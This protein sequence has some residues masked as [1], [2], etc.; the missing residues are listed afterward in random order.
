MKTKKA[1][2]IAVAALVAVAAAAALFMIFTSGGEATPDSPRPAKAKRAIAEPTRTNAQAR[3]KARRGKSNGTTDTS[4]VKRKRRR[5]RVEDPYTPAERRLADNLQDASDENDI[6]K[7]REAVAKIMSQKNPDL[8]TEAI[9]SLGFFG[10]D[11]LSDLMVFLKDPS[12]EVVDSATDAISSALS[13]LDDEE[14]GFR[15]EFISTLLSVN[16]L[17][18]KESIDTFVG[19]LESIGASDEKLA[20]Q[21]MVRLIEDDK[22]GKD[23]KSRLKEAYEFVTSEKYSTFEAA[24]KWWNSKTEE[25]AAEA[26]EPADDVKDDSEDSGENTEKGAQT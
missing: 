23:A 26:A 24:E 16:G 7:V 4:T 6:G 9:A 20:V 15:A 25:E 10:K 22:V 8:K 5:I 17:C 11:A 18:G 1:F 14:N 2:A 21:T 3:V 12:Q 19:Q 13:E